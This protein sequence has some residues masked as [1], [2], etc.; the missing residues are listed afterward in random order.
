[1]KGKGA[2]RR[3]TA[4]IDLGGGVTRRILA[5]NSQLM[6]VEVGF[7]AG[8]VGSTHT[9]P[10]T[11]LTFVGAGKFEFTIGGE[12]KIVSAGDALYMEPNVEHGCT[13]L[14]AGYLIDCFNPMR[15]TFIGK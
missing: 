4:H 9:H 6:A 15:E 14:E 7:E 12:T 10:H 5:H 8:A 3:D 2:L 1:M 11:Q 13:C